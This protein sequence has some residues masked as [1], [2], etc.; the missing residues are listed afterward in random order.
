[1]TPDFLKEFPN[2]HPLVVHFPIVLILLAALT[3]FMVLFFQKNNQLKW[4]S[5][6]LMAFAAIGAFTAYQTGV[7]ISG[8]AD[9]KA[10][11]IFETHKLLATIT[12][13]TSI[14]AMVIRFISLKWFSKKWI[15]MVLLIVF[16]SAAVLVSI[17]AHHGAQMVYVYGV[18]PMGNGVMND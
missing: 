6:L 1:M 2:L 13:W 3:Q 10:I 17:T 5:F 15:E 4:L 11:E 18:G 7:H 12:L 16:L 8:D 14:F 9:E